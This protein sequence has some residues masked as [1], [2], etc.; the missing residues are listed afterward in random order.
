[1]LFSTMPRPASEVL[2][3]FIGE[4]NTAALLKRRGRPVG[5]GK[6]VATN[7]RLD[8]DLVEAFKITG[9]GWQTRMNDALRDWAKKHWMLSR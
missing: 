7:I 2:P 8:S 6:K 3:A 9:N 1:M 5:S 4:V